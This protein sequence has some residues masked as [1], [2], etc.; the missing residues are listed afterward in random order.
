MTL[1]TAPPSAKL[2]PRIPCRR[3]PGFAPERRGQNI[4]R[5]RDV[6]Y[7]GLCF[8]QMIL[9]QRSDLSKVGNCRTSQAES[10][11]DPGEV[12]TTKLHFPVGHS[13]QAKLV[14]LRTVSAIVERNDQHLKAM[15]RDRFQLLDMHD[16]AAIA[17]DEQDFP[18]VARDGDADGM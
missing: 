8:R 10:A 11:S 6:P 4:P 18:T 17:V 12:G 15:A 2:R 7:L 9:E 16:Q 13:I 3:L 1:R 14:H 5:N